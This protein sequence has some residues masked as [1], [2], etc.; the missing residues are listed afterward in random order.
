MNLT[1]RVRA[2][3]CHVARFHPITAWAHI[4]QVYISLFRLGAVLCAYVLST[5]VDQAC[6]PR[7]GSIERVLTDITCSTILSGM[8]LTDVNIALCITIVVSTGEL[9]VI[10][11]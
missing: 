2:S 3:S 8:P 9:T 1:F 7:A 5:A 4:R 11:A 6:Q 10:F